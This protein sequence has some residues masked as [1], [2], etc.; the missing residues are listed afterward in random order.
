MGCQERRQYHFTSNSPLMNQSFSSHEINSLILWCKLLLASILMTERDL[1]GFLQTRMGASYSPALSDA[2]FKPWWCSLSS[3]W[4]KCWIV[5]NDNS[6]HDHAQ[7]AF[8][9]SMPLP[10]RAASPEKEIW[11]LGVEWQQSDDESQRQ[12]RMRTMKHAALSYK[13][14]ISSKDDIFPSDKLFSISIGHNPV[15]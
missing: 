4:D 7:Q 12:K 3:L 6:A 8:N 1:Q 9:E 11:D 13:G 14:R 2:D 5:Q 10:E 15:L